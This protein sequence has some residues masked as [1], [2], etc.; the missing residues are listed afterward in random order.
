MASPEISG[1]IRSAVLAALDQ[2]G[3]LAERLAAIAARTRVERPEFAAGI[4]RFVARIRDACAGSNAPKPGEL[5][6]PFILPDERGR[7]VTLEELLANGPVA[8]C[9]HRGHWCPFCKMNMI[10]LAKAHRMI[11]ALRGHLVA[12]T[13]ERWRFAT[14]LKTQAGA[15]FPALT[16]MD[17]G[18]ALS[19]GIAV[20]LGSEMEGLIT[21]R[22]HKLP[23]YQGNKA[24]IVPIPATFVVRRDGII[25]ARYLNPDYRERMSIEDLA[26]ALQQAR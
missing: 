11:D 26:A 25:T 21:A 16:D 8:V 18:Y 22:G 17:N 23:L 19:L 15:D 7:L 10:A 4:D 5:L 12:I 1:E 14:A 13:P 9:F 20:W 2:D 24:F 3:S 6:P